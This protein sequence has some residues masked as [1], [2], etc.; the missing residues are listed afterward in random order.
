MAKQGK[1]KASASRKGVVKSQAGRKGKGKAKASASRA[2]GWTEMET[3]M[4]IHEASQLTNSLS[5]IMSLEEKAK[6]WE[7]VAPEIARACGTPM[8]RTT[9]QCQ[10]KWRSLL[11]DYRKNRDWNSKSGAA[12][13]ES[14]WYNLMRAA[15]ANFPNCNMKGGIDSGRA[16]DPEIEEENAMEGGH[17]QVKDPVQD[18]DETEDEDWELKAPDSEDDEEHDS[19]NVPE[20]AP[21]TPIQTPGPSNV[22]TKSSSRGGSSSGFKAGSKK[23]AQPWGMASAEEKASIREH[24]QKVEEYCSIL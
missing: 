14:K 13:R 2:P 15:T 11:A 23:R 21:E 5:S 10:Q 20:P 19:L 18:D 4:L 16:E 1:G 22:V 17:A 6:E 12:R 24:Y 3:R 8:M 9:T 7:K